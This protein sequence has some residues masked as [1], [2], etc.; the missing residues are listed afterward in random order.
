[1]ATEKT[2]VALVLSGGVSLGSYI[3]GALEELLAAFAQT[4]QYEIDIITGASAGATTGAI[5]AHGLLYRN[6]QSSLRRVWVEGVDITDLLDPTPPDP[7]EG[8][9][10]LSSKRLLA[11][12]RQ[13][14]QWN[15]ADTP[16]RA[17][18]CADTLTLAM[19]LGNATP[20][21][22]VSRIRQQADGRLEDFSQPRN[23]EQETFHLPMELAP[24]DVAY[25]Q[26]VADV[27][28][29]SA[30]IPFVFPL[31]R[32]EREAANPDHYIQ[33]PAFDGRAAFWY[34]DGGTFNNLPVDLAWHYAGGRDTA[35]VNR[36]LIIINPWRNKPSLVPHDMARPAPLSLAQSLLGGLVNESTA[37]QFTHEVL[38]RPIALTPPDILRPARAI[39]GV[40]PAPVESLTDVA[41]IMPRKDDPDLRGN[42]LMAL[43]AFLDRTFR[44][45][46]F[47][48]G[49]AD[50]RAVARNVLQIVYTAPHPDSYYDPESDARLQADLSDYANLGSIRRGNGEDRSVQATL[51]SALDAR[52][53]TLMRAWNAPGPD[54]VLDPLVAAFVKRLVKQQLPQVW[55]PEST[56]HT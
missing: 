56:R 27:A 2:K 19:T 43:G 52:I 15:P 26:R 41:L 28:R 7:G 17:P 46:D 40:D 21:P 3:A 47:R 20:L 32:L 11:I 54:L 6:G 12:A 36:K 14:L 10:L 48:R 51:E 18:F 45:Y 35:P 22:Y 37:I 44:E 25:W 34:F 30:A 5:I 50:A 1:M 39:P 31:V 23:S 55:L 16:V 53:D 24:P 38:R 13:E 4:N 8:L 42:H 29:A 49:A 9:S 33:P